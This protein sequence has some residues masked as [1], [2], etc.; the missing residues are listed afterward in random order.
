MI[1]NHCYGLFE[2]AAVYLSQT[3][4]RLEQARLAID[5]LGHIVEGLGDRLGAAHGALRDALAQV[6]L[7]FVQIG[8][9]EP[10][11]PGGQRPAGASP[12]APA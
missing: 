5:G 3:P 7:A 6:R 11:T 4:P 1:A 9:V 8:S 12:S 10:D 2:L